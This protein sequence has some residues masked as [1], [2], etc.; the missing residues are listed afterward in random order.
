[1]LGGV[2]E[3]DPGPVVAPSGL[4]QSV[5]I[6]TTVRSDTGPPLCIHHDSLNCKTQFTVG[7]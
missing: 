5:V 2:G 6:H 4:R 7:M 1:M 3:P